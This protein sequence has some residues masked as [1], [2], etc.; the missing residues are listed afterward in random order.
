MNEEYAT[1]YA[2]GYETG[3]NAAIDSTPNDTALLTQ[4]L[5]ALEWSEP[6]GTVGAG[7]IAAR[8][9]SIDALKERLK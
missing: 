4:A 1:G 3:W 9:A 8:R 2:N 6:A 5:E 7:G